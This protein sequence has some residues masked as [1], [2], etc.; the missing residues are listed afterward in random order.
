MTR[1]KQKQILMASA[2]AMC[3][4]FL[5]WIG[6]RHVSYIEAVPGLEILL[7][8]IAMPGIFVEVLLEAAFSPQGFHDGKTFARIVS[9]SNL[10]LYFTF[11]LMLIKG[12]RGESDS[13]SLQ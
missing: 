5:G 1:K 11:S 13:G 3:S 6:L 10:A 9:P 12:F 7:G 8:M 2:V 4:A